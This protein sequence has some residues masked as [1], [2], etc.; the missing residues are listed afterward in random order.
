MRK[1]FLYL[2]YE[3]SEVVLG[4]ILGCLVAIILTIYEKLGG[5]LDESAGSL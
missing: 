2:F 4:F 1:R 5:K 3:L